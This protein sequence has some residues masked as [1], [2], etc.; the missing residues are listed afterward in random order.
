V[1]A[2]QHGTTLV[3]N[4]LLRIKESDAKQSIQHLARE[5]GSVPDVGNLNTWRQRKGLR[6]IRPGV[7]ILRRGTFA[8]TLST[9]LSI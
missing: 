4:D 1:R 5:Q 9:G 2:R 8:T 3:P 7:S 6:P